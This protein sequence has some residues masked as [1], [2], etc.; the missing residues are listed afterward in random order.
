MSECAANHL[1]ARPENPFTGPF[2]AHSSES[3]ATKIRQLHTPV[4]PDAVIDNEDSILVQSRPPTS[5]KISPVIG[6]ISY[7]QHT[8][9]QLGF[10]A[11]GLL[12]SILDLLKV[13]GNENSFS[14][15]SREGRNACIERQLRSKNGTSW[16]LAQPGCFVCKTCFNKK[17]PCMRVVG[18][19][20]WLLLPLPPDV[21]DPGLTWMDEA[22]YVYQGIGS[23]LSFP[24]TWELSKSAVIQRAM[25]AA[26]A[27]EASGF[28][29]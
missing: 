23:N 25:K 8:H 2:S 27:R 16:S 6:S 17:R 12:N 21:R 29:E 20:Q 11:P 10:L 7:T 15:L 28:T 18:R 24:G 19:H 3:T 4:S 1:A 5:V 14:T 26:T 9:G 22:Y 13:L